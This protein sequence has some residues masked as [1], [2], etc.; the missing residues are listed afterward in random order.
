MSSAL[1]NMQRRVL[2]AKPDYEQ[3]D[4]PT[5]TLRD[6]GYVTLRP[7]KGFRRIT[8][9]RLFAQQRMAAMLDHALPERARKAPKVWR[10]PAPVPPSTETRQQRRFAA[11]H[12]V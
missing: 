10:E 5:A 3:A 1:R 4:Q 2:R 11:R 8:G 6:G 9:A 7:T 12:T